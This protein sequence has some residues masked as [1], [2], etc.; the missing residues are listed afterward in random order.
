MNVGEMR[1]RGRRWGG[2]VGT[3]D[4]AGRRAGRGREVNEM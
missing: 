3:W 2:I 1:M 4:D